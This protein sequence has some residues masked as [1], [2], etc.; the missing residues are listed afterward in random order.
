MGHKVNSRLSR[1][2]VPVP[3]TIASLALSSCT[4]NSGTTSPTTTRPSAITTPITL[5]AAELSPMLLTLKDMPAGWTV[6]GSRDRGF[7]L[8]AS[9]C[10]SLAR[11]LQQPLVTADGS[12]GTRGVILPAWNEYQ[13]VVPP[14]SKALIMNEIAAEMNSGCLTGGVVPPKL[15]R[16]AFPTVGDQSSAWV[17]PWQGRTIYHVFVRFGAVVAMFSVVTRHGGSGLF[18]R[19]GVKAARKIDDA[20]G[21]T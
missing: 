16:I 3:V 20:L 5:T 21:R 15:A 12:F 11:V 13:T 7:S 8:M 14:N 19:L 10:P 18:K 4:S 6:V 9:K 17:F 2:L 1:W